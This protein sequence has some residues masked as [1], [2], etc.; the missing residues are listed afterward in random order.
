VH[1]RL[2]GQLANNEEHLSFWHTPKPRI[3]DEQQSHGRRP[4]R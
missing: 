2:Q 4:A 1:G 3:H